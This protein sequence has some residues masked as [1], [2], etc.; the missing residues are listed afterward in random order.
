MEWVTRRDG[1]VELVVPNRLESL[2]RIDRLLAQLCDAELE[3]EEREQL[4][5][6][7]NE[8]CENAWE[9]GNRKEP[10]RKIRV[11]Y[12]LFRDKVVFKIEDEGEGF[13]PGSVPDPTRN[14]RSLLEQRT[15]LGQRA[16]GFG[17]HMVRKIMDEVVYNDKGNVVVL[18][19]LLKRRRM[20]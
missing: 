7:L 16:G 20:S 13:D 19:K 15:S 9:W 1:W 2:A 18:S 11:G 6:A 5:Y 12:C 4:H 14:L 17:L 8:I 3:A 10:G